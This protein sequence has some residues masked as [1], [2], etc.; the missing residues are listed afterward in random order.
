MEPAFSDGARLRG[1]TPMTTSR[2]TRAIGLGLT[3]LLAAAVVLL[4][5]L[6]F[7]RKVESFQPVGFDAV[8][9]GAA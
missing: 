9:T 2:I 5:G 6:S 7:Q 3:F 4:G 1:G 8:A